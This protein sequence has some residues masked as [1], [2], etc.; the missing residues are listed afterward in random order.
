MYEASK[1]LGGLQGNSL[2]TT[3]LTD[4]IKGFESSLNRLRSIDEILSQTVSRFCLMDPCVGQA[5]PITD[6][7]RPVQPLISDLA[8]TEDAI[9][10]VIGQI[11]NRVSQL[12]S[13]L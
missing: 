10:Q 1:P 2:K 12:T 13:A 8:M 4:A 5:N 9:R 6:S 11:E 3:T 7:P